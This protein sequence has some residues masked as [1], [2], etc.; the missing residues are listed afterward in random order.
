M[1]M[2]STIPRRDFI[3][4]GVWGSAGLITARVVPAE[5]VPAPHDHLVQ[6][7]A[8]PPAAAKPHTLW[9]WMDGNVSKAGITADLEAMQRIGLGGAMIYSLG[10]EI[11]LGPV[12]YASPQWREMIRHAASEANRLGLEL[13]MHNSSGW[14]STGGPWVRPDLA[15]QK[16]VWSETRVKSAARFAG[17]LP[18]P[19]AG[20]WKDYYRDIAVLACRAPKAERTT[21]ED[22]E[23]QLTTSLPGDTPHPFGGRTAALNISFATPGQNPQYLTLSFSRPFTAR[24]LCLASVAGHG[25]VTCTV[26]VSDDNKEYRPAARFVLPRRGMPN[27]NFAPETAR[28]FRLAFTGEVLDSIPFVVSGIDLVTGYRLP[29]WAAKAGFALME[30]FTPDWDAPCPPELLYRAADIVVLSERM[31]PDGRLEWEA[32]AGDWIILRFGYAPTGAKNIHAEAEGS[33]LEVD[34]MN[35]QALDA[36]FEG[37]LDAVLGELGPLAGQGLNTILVD[38]Y[39]VGP[40]NW[41]GAFPAEFR[42][43]CGYDIIPFLPAL[44]GRVIDSPET[45]ERILWDLR[46]TI[47]AL[48]TENY[49]GHFRARCHEKGLKI[50]SEP[51]VGPFSPIDCGS[52]SDLPIGEFWTGKLFPENK[53]V[54]RRVVAGAHLNGRSV[55]GAE[56]FTSRFDIDRFTLDPAA[57]KADGDAQFCEGITR[58]IIHRFAQQPWLDKAPG[59]TMGPWGLHFDRT[60]TWW[61]PGRAWIEYLTRCQHLLQSGKPVT[62]ILCFDGEDGQ[63]LSRWGDGTLPVLPAG[64]DFEFT[65]PAFLLTAE[66]EDGDIVLTNGVRYRLLALPDMRHLTLPVARK[67]AALVKAGAVIAGPPPLRSPGFAGHAA[68]DAEIGRIVAELWGDCDGKTVTH[69]LCGKGAVYWGAPLS[70]VLAARGIEPDFAAAGPAQ[71]LFKHRSTPEAEIY[72]VSN[73]APRETTITCRFRVKGRAPELWDP[74]TG[75]CEAAALYRE[76][77]HATAVPLTLGPCGSLFVV[78]RDNGWADHA[79]AASGNLAPGR[80]MRSGRGF[81]VEAPAAGRYAITTAKG[82]TLHADVAVPPAPKDLSAEWNVAFPPGTGAP[83][84]IALS[85]LASLSLHPDS[86]VRYFSGTATYTKIIDLPA[87]MLGAGREITLDLGEVKNLARVRV[88]EIDFGVLWKPPFRCPVTAAL[89]PG[90]N[91]IEVR[92]TNLWVNRLIGDEQLADDC[93][94]IA[95]PDRGARI[96]EWPQ[97][98]VENTPRPGRRVTFTT[99]KFYAKD[100]ALAASGL[101]GPVR[102]LTA[103]KILLHP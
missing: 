77:E 63:A 47:A 74:E 6:G 19:F 49:Y 38:S 87:T 45:T 15:M 12:R 34:K 26:E 98:L 103:Q 33:G 40:Q 28:H 73:Q 9:H 96:K 65:N 60:V 92:V 79:V 7:F 84:A 17:I 100:D 46:H 72:F 62:D 93:A 101:I 36:H 82:R 51:Y 23:V 85:R 5:A 13:G 27:I 24:G 42:R 86:G 70:A 68:A 48:F 25:K 37:L 99:W 59:M 35:P 94:W 80:L 88:N 41:T 95:V 56:A 21:L 69:H 52:V 31:G 81:V 67:L 75:R 10:Y 14:S 3:K 71:I 32:P 64:Y 57:L 97:W 20:K 66:V 11:P 43:R 8:R 2:D 58:F 50:A 61:E 4:A 83:K 18:R 91:R 78:F 53:S 90:K 29:D 55:V 102:L 30:R 39:E 54:G 1:A 22:M 44:S 76:D 89:R 16:V